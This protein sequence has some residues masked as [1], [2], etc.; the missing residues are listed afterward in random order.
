MKFT[1]LHV[2][3]EYSLLDAMCRI[4]EL[5]HRAK[6]LGMDAIALTDH[7]VLHGAIQFYEAAK[8]A[9]IKPIIG[10]E[11]YLAHGSRHSKTAADREIYHL[12]LLAKNNTGYKNLI[13]LVSLANTEGFYYKP[14]MDKE[15]L[16]KYSEGLVALTACIAGE[17]PKL[18]LNS[19]LP[20]AREAA[21]WYQRVFGNDFYIELQRHPLPEL[22]QVNK[23]LIPLARELGIPMVATNDVHYI[24]SGDSAPHDL[25]L[26]IGTNATVFEEK[27]KKMGGDY[28]YLKSPEEMA[29][30]FS[31][32]P[33]AIENSNIIADKCNL[34]ID[35]G[36]LHLPQIDIPEG[37]TP[38]EYLKDLCFAGLEAYYPEANQEI[39]DRLNYELDVI[40]QTDFANYF[41]VVWDIV[42]FVRREGIL[43]N[44]RGSAASS[45]VLR[46]LGIT[47]VD[48]IEHKLVFER[49]LNIERREMP[50][51]DLDFAD[52]RR[53][54]VINY[55][56]QKYGADH[57]AQIITFG[58][59][60]AR[61][62]I[63]DVGRALGMPY[64][65]VDRIARLVPFSPG[66]T[67]DKALEMSEELRQLKSRDPSVNNVLETAKRVEGLS[68][69]A[70]T[71]AAGVVIAR[72]PL[73]DH[74]PLQLLSR[75]DNNGL[76][77]T[78]YPMGDI[79]KIGLLKMDFLGLV[80]LTILGKARDII[81]TTRKIKIDL[82][83]IPLDDV[84]TYKLLSS[85]ETAGV[86][87]LE[88]SGMRRYI[89]ELKP[90]TFGDIAAMVALYRPGPMEQI[91]HFIKSKHGLEPIHYPHPVLADIL[92]DTYGVIV[93]QEQV[94]FIV[95]AF[96][97]Y[98]L[99]QADIFRK[100]MGK[101]IAG[102]MK[103]ER[104]NFIDGALKLGYPEKIADE[105]FS[106]IEPFAGY[107]FNKAHAV[108]Y[109]LVAYQT[110]YLK[111]NYP[112]E[113][114]TALLTS[115]LG[116]AEKLATAFGECRNL[117]IRV[118]PPCVNHSELDF[119]IEEQEEG[120]TG[121]RFGLSGIK[122]VGSNAVEPLVE[123]RKKNGT[124]SSIED[125]CR[126]V[127]L[128]AVNRRALES[129]IKAGAMDDLGERGTLLAGLPRI[130]AL[131]ERQQKLKSTGQTTMFD[132]W[133]SEAE[134]PLPSLELEASQVSL[135]EKLAWEKELMGVYL[136]QHPFSPYATQVNADSD[137]VLCGQIDEE[138]EDKT[139]V[140]AGMVASIRNL[141]TRDG[142]A[143]VSAVLEDME[144][145][146]EVVA[147]PRVY[148]GSKELWQEGN[149]LLVQ[150]KIKAR[151]D[152]VQ[153]VADSASMYELNTRSEE[154][155]LTQKP[156]QEPDT[157]EDRKRVILHMDQTEDE[158]S[159]LGRLDRLIGVLKRYPGSDRVGMVINNGSRIYRME[160]P[161]TEIKYTPQL[162]KKLAEILG[163]SGVTVTSLN[164][165]GNGSG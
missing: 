7:G 112:V 6:E 33:E 134:T 96:A 5:V 97:G 139:V 122:N 93:Y 149:I 19:R 60:G 92:E 136:S 91:P 78:Q 57:V 55:V 109:A 128:G 106:L 87:Q 46:C 145:S 35:F 9:G 82:P 151:G 31:D 64:S 83:A 111:A 3:T 27:R 116:H 40:R 89:R 104:K 68:R 100:A 53:D 20:E 80:N 160:L 47:E 29:E 49:F 38:L 24:F 15:I 41:L 121:I 66:M 124:F 137:V 156:A 119:A 2:H 62:A 123:E 79:A 85:G 58:T 37:K 30:Q 125:L 147:W 103:K 12:V 50:D 71:H 129:M 158:E 154:N 4:P 84:K 32:I 43:F 110:A 144:G 59:M 81:F 11:V 95:R 120:S 153:I 99:G 54:E 132:L 126:R 42:S 130:M 52:T 152:S 165:T 36:R 114:M 94:L 117:G 69:H 161:D 159:D 76:V 28:F 155:I 74:C 118:L 113:Y 86:F 127:N 90:S 162:H 150:G 61:A 21:K 157:Y 17:I 8:E 115:Y 67:I 77:M 163:S 108:S 140:V 22:D 34:E 51:I 107:A 72:D 14:R 131:S 98:T 26:C 56:S 101:K 13:R 105:V 25:L 10:C 39:T 164:G 16:E 75:G 135:K 148:A 65:D 88:G 138:M 142:K 48:P 45:I 1:H 23:E 141:T 143:S 73:T 44:V 63:R 70:S 133:G 146:V 18:I 102:A